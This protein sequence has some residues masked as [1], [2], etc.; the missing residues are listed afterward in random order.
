M[1]NIYVDTLRTEVLGLV[2]IAVKERGLVKV[3]FFQGGER[4]FVEGLKA[5]KD[6]QVIHCEEKTGPIL[7]Q[8]QQYL[9][10]ERQEFEVKIDWS[11]LTDFQRAVLRATLDIPFGETRSYGDIAALVGKPG[12]ARAVGQAESRNPY[13]LI[14]PCHRVIGAD[15][16]MRGYGGSGGVNTKAW[17]LSFESQIAERRRIP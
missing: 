3:N 4:G 16:G 2:G 8:I 6:L 12:A 11:P 7:D 13:P 14:V 17:L 9:Q 5:G 1:D 10:G 15:G